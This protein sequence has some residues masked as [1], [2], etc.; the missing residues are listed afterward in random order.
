[1]SWGDAHLRRLL[2]GLDSVI[3]AFVF[4]HTHAA[5][6]VHGGARI[7]R[8]GSILLWGTLC[9]TYTRQQKAGAEKHARFPATPE[10]ASRENSLHSYSNLDSPS[11]FKLASLCCVRRD[12]YLLVV[13]V[14]Y[15]GKR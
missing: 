13:T 5:I 8:S 11:T 3:L 1:M 9:G 14:H 12:M 4:G 7:G 15:F 6:H 2:L 10:K